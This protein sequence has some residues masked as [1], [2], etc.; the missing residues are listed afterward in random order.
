MTTHNLTTLGSS[1]PVRLTP[2]GIHSGMDITLQNT[3]ASNNV[4]IGGEDVTS[5]SYGFK[6]VPGTAISFE[7]SGQDAL[8]A[9]ASG[10]STNLAV[11]MTSLEVG[12]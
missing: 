4:F 10:S 6:L 7:L 12:S 1:A 11:L 9:I 5:S 3:H 2:N 8:Y